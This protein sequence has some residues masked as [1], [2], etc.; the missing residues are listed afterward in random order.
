M[1]SCATR[2]ERYKYF[3]YNNKY[4]YHKTKVILRDDFV[5]RY[6]YKGKNIWKYA[7][8]SNRFVV[9]GKNMYL[10]YKEYV[11]WYILKQN[12][13]NQDYNQTCPYFVLEEEMLGVAIEGF[14]K[15]IV[16]E[17]KM[18]IG[19][20]YLNTDTKIKGWATYIFT[21]FASLIFKEFYLIW[22][23]ATVIFYYYIKEKNNDI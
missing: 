8:F 7:W 20:K 13:A 3:P 18:L 21:L 15:P 22:I 9:N 16:I 10:F 5:N 6:T 19:N 14:T 12:N 1:S 11:D 2:D 17:P 23:V 4:Y